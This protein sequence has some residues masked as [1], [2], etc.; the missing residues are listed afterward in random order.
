MLTCARARATVDEI[1]RRLPPNAERWLKSPAEM[2]ALFA[3]ARRRCARRAPSPSAARSR[4]PTS[5]TPSPAIPCRPARPQQSYLEKMTWLG[6]ARRYPPAIRRTR[7]L[8]KVRAQ[9][10]RELAIIGK[11]ELAGYFL[12][13]WDIVEYARAQ[14]HHDPGARLGGELGHLLR[15][16]HHRRR[17]GGDGAAVR[18]LPVRGARAE[19]QQRRRPHARHRSRS[20]VGRSPRA[21]DPARLREV[22]RARRRHDRQRDH[23]SPAHGGARHRPRARLLRG[24]ARAHLQAPARLDHGRRHAARD[25]H[26]RGRLPRDRST[27]RS[28]WPRSPPR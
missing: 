7:L 26:R 8:P 27:A 24:A 18:A 9:I 1:G 21:G 14:R 28:C 23:L 10:A 3:I 15:P 11:L 6:V 25:L 20:A 13:V 17:S 12:V 22:R 2:A 5:A 16:R 4:S 19:R